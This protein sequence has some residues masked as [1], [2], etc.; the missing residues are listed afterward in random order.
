MTFVSVNKNLMNNHLGESQLRKLI[1]I[2]YG[3]KVKYDDLGEFE[4]GLY[5]FLKEEFPSRNV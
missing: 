5:D 2:Y 3:D 4:Q 1:N